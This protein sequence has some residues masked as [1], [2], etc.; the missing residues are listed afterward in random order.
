MLSSCSD[1]TVFWWDLL[2]QIHSDLRY[3]D[4]GSDADRIERNREAILDLR[5]WLYEQDFKSIPP[6]FPRDPA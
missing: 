5:K 4:A 3:I 2:A 6:R 1:R